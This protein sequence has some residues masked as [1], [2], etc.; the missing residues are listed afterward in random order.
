M[1]SLDEWLVSTWNPSR[2]QWTLVAWDGTLIGIEKCRDHSRIQPQVF[3]Y[4]AAQV[5][6]VREKVKVA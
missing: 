5:E 3:G 6:R 2:C 4:L 1:G